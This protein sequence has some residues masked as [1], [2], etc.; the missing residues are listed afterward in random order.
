MVI[1]NLFGNLNIEVGDD[2]N[3]SVAT[4][5]ELSRVALALIEKYPDNFNP[6]SLHRWESNTH[7]FPGFVDLVLG[8][9]PNCDYWDT[10]SYYALENPIQKVLG[11][12]DKEWDWL[13]DPQNSLARL[14]ALHKLLFVDGVFGTNGY[15]ENG[16][17]FYCFDSFGYDEDGFDQFGYDRQGVHRSSY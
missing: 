13:T 7:S 1:L 16:F 2:F 6:T 14:K 12:T 4:P 17:D 3:P 8:A 9:E 5:R 11:L 15:D 10:M